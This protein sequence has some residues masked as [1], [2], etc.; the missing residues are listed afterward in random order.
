ME[1][2]HTPICVVGIGEFLWDLLPA[3][4]QL[5]GAPANFAYHAQALGAESVV[6]S[7]VGD[8]SLGRDLIEQLERIGL[9][10]GFIA[11]D[12]ERPTG[13]V[14]VQLDAKGVPDF[15]IHEGVAWDAIPFS[16][17]LKDLAQKA[18]CVCFGT[19]AQRC[20]ISRHTIQNFVRSTR[21][22]CLRIYDVN[23]RQ[24]YYDKP[25]VDQ[26]LAHTDV[27][28]LNEQELPDLARL[29]SITGSDSEILKT[30]LKAYELELIA[31]T[32]GER[33]SRLVGLN[34]DSFLET[35][36]VHVE[37]TVGAGDAFTAALAMGLLQN[38]PINTIHQN[39]TRLAAF[40]CTQ[41][42]A[43]PELQ[44]SKI[45]ELIRSEKP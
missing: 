20:E 19:L 43:T 3:G 14:T 35:P 29:L 40:V 30:L 11:R 32:Q 34:D 5:G 44:E 27:L 23:F 24:H 31:L 37:D 7:A 39:A 17:E 13:T 28:K 42:G 16:P 26:S 38:L 12:P 25:I 10:D 41:K 33:G 1:Q 2:S 15:T 45:A 9:D 18:D 22:D 36:A 4:R 8:D 6:V 21:P